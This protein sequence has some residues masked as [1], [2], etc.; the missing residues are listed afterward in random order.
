MENKAKLLQLKLQWGQLCKIKWDQQIPTG[1]ELSPQYDS[2][3][4]YVNAQRGGNTGNKIADVKGVILGKWTRVLG[5][6]NSTSW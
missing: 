3:S 1:S 2:L 6:H 5:G 4:S